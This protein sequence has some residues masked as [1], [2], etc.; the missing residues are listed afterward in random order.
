MLNSNLKEAAKLSMKELATAWLSIPVFSIHKC[1]TPQEYTCWIT[2][3][4]HPFI[5]V[6]ICAVFGNALTIAN[7]LVWVPN[8]DISV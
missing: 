2:T 3:Q 5:E 4:L 6:V 7:C 1:F 8:S